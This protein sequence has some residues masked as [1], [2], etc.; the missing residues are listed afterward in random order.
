MNHPGF[1]PARRA[2]GRGALLAGTALLGT[3]LLGSGCAGGLLPKPAAAPVRYTLGDGAPQG[4]A[5]PSARPGALS[6]VVAPLTAAPGFD[7]ARMLYLRQPRVL[8]AYAYAEWA[9][10]PA[11]LLAPLLLRALQH[12]G[13]FGAVLQ[14]PSSASGP[15]RLETELLQLQHLH[16]RSPSELQLALRV[17]LV[18]TATR[19]ALFTRRFEVRVPAASDDPAGGAAAAALAAQQLLAELAAQVAAEAVRSVPA[20]TAGARR[21]P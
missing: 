8:Q 15:L 12:T 1:Y 11:R 9:D 7:S 4:P 5:A 13:A 21:E 14:A 6:L 16:L 18:D 19:Q 20:L 17:V 10:T 2:A 3:T